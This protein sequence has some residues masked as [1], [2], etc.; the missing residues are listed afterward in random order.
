MLNYFAIPIRKREYADILYLHPDGNT[1]SYLH[2]YYYENV[3]RA[4]SGN[5]LIQNAA[6]LLTLLTSHYW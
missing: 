6:A 1:A 4:A 2:R 3:E 5:N